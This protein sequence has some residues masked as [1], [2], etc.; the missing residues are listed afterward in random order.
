MLD[1]IL[2]L[3]VI[4]NFFLYPYWQD[5]R[6]LTHRSIPAPNGQH[7]LV[8]LEKYYKLLNE[9]MLGWQ[10]SEFLSEVPT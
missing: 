3:G 1:C 6:S 9:D 5:V 8:K 7:P 10:H 2:Q 4:S